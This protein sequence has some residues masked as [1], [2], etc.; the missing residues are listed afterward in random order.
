MKKTM[1]KFLKDGAKFKLSIR[2]KVFWQL[3]TKYKENGKKYA[4]ITAT[5]S[6]ITKNKEVDTVCWVEK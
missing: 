5:I 4:T 3:Q 1:I 2:S 6:G